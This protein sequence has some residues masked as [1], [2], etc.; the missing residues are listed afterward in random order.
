MSQFPA[1][2]APSL[3]RTSL[4]LIVAALLLATCIKWL[5]L[6]SPAGE[7]WAWLLLLSQGVMFVWLTVPV[8]EDWLPLRPEFV[9]PIEP[10]ASPASS[11]PIVVPQPA[12][13]KLDTPE[14]RPH[15]PRRPIEKLV[16]PEQEIALAAHRT[17]PFSIGTSISSASPARDS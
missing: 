9:I 13:L 15:S 17:S 12:P 14:T 1:W 6:R 7:Q 8:P 4:S 5:R 10:S 3:L 11:S 16:A 2:F